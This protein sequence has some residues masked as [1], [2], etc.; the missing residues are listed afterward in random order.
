MATQAPPPPHAHPLVF[1]TGLLEANATLDA[2][3]PGA[4]D[5]QIQPD[6]AAILGLRLATDAPF[7]AQSKTMSFQGKLFVGSTQA[8]TLD[9]ATVTVTR[10]AN[11]ST[12]AP[13]LFIT[14]S[15][16]A[17]SMQF[18]TG[19]GAPTGE[20]LG[21]PHGLYFKN[22]AGGT[23]YSWGFPY[24]D[25][26]LECNWNHEHR[27]HVIREY[28]FVDWFDLWAGV[29]HRVQGAMFHC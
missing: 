13:F 23:M 5:V 18:R 27:Y 12:G 7:T 21:M 4:A 8:A 14:F 2:A 24:D 19:R 20:P 1:E 15:Y 22:S 29:Q 17:T 26:R 10:M 11:P 16:L 6:A 25:F 3:H 9:E 28:T